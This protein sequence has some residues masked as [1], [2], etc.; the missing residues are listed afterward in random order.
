[1]Y[2]IKLKS[3]LFDGFLACWT[4]C[5]ALGAIVFWLAGSPKKAIRAASRLWVRGV[6]FKLKYIVGLDYAEKNRDLIPP[7]PCLIVCNHQS[8]W[9]TL[10]FLVL[11]PDVAIVAKQELLRIPIISWY[12]RKSPMIIIDRESG[13]KALK[14]MLRQS[15]EAIAGGRSV[16]IFPQGTRMGESEPIRF[17]RGVELLYSKLGTPVLPVVVNSGKFW[18]IGV[19]SKRSGTITVSY[20]PAISPGM[21]AEQF[22]QEAESQM[23]KERELLF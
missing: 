20:L 12:L 10:A 8:T 22:V 16:L 13:S 6:L 9:E 19:S 18:G 2:Q 5:F 1:M 11:F 4:S 23:E 15:R 7:E 14:A 3:R 21:P 17:K